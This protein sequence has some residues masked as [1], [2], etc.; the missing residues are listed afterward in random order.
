MA[1]ATMVH[2]EEAKA[3]KPVYEPAVSSSDDEGFIPRMKSQD[4]KGQSEGRPLAG[5]PGM[6]GSYMGIWKAG[7]GA[8]RSEGPRAEVFVVT[9]GKGSVWI[10]GHGTH[11]LE[12]GVIIS[13]AANTPA[14]ITITEGEL[15]KVSFVDASRCPIGQPSPTNC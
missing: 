12:P 1:S 9:H 7:P 15:R 3:P 5:V 13:T 4:G 8:Y 6:E 14:V 10:Q 2:A 11:A